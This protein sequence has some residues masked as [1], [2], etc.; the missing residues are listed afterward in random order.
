MRLADVERP[1]PGKGQILIQVAAT[2]VNRPDI[3]QRQGHYPPPPGE[4]EIL[5]LE[6]A[7][8]VCAIGS[9]VTEPLL[10]QR[11]AAL[12]PGGGYAEYALAYAGHAI[13]IPDWMEDA[14]AACIPEVYVTAWQNLILNAGLEDGETVLLHG[15]GGGVNM[16]AI[17][18]CRALTPNSRILVTASSGKL[19]RVRNLGAHEVIDY[20][21]ESFPDRVRELTKGRGVNVVLDY[22]GGPYLANNLKSLAVGGRLALIGTLGGRTAEIDL[23][24]L[25]VK[26]QTI[27]GSVLRSRSIEEKTQIISRFAS[28]VMPHFSENMLPVIDCRL[29][30]EEAAAAHQRMEESAHFGK[31]ILEVNRTK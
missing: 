12:L 14:H 26:R 6:A 21:T 27:I 17:Q 10:E 4:S 2:S 28:E 13:A 20:R 22:I 15:G 18:I 23:T 25:L 9:D 1:S 30:L 5:G 31:I 11:V 7:G 29:P 8:R 3:I 24:R 19:D 16:A